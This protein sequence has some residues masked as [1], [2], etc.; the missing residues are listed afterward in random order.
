M[1]SLTTAVQGSSKFYAP[2]K[3]FG[4]ST[5]GSSSNNASG[6]SSNSVGNVDEEGDGQIMFGR[7][8]PLLQELSEYLSRC[9][10]V[11]KNVV[12]QLASLY[13]TNQKLYITSFK[14]V[15][16]Q[17]VFDN[18]SDL[19]TVLITLDEIITTNQAFNSAL[20]MYKRYV[21]CGACS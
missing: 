17:T 4:E 8:L 11:C 20:N 5:S 18:L 16:L 19:F 14:G 6:Q 12:H 21:S 7:I 9:Y 1:Q 15:H 3:L 2:L 10:L 13:N